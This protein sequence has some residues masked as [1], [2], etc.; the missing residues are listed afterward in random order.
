MALLHMQFPISGEIGSVTLAL[1]FGI[2]LLAVDLSASCGSNT[3]HLFG[4][5]LGDGPFEKENYSKMDSVIVAC[6]SN[7]LRAFCC[8]LQ[9]ALR[10][11]V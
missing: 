5:I 4:S 11:N 3:D 9:V 10:C 2:H 8:V 6:A 7:V 1:H